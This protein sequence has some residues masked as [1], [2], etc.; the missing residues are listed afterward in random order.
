MSPASWPKTGWIDSLDWM[1]NKSALSMF[2]D[3][4]DATATVYHRAVVLDYME[5]HS[6]PVCYT[7]LHLTTTYAVSIVDL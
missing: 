1:N 6:Y 4:D 7:I 2:S 5:M 3:D